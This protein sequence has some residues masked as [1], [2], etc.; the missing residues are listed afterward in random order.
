MFQ[1]VMIPVYATEEQKWITTK[2]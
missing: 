1:D 2:K